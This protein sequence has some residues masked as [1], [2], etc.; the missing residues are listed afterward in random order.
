[1]PETDNSAPPLLDE[2]WLDQLRDTLEATNGLLICLDFDGTL[3]PIVDDPGEATIAPEN[4]PLLR[5]LAEDPDVTVVVVSGRSLS[6]LREHVGVDGIHYAGNHG[7]EWDDG[8]GRTVAPATQGT[9]EALREALGRIRS[10][11]ADIDGCT[12]EDKHLTATVHYRRVSDAQRPTVVEV[13]KRVVEPTDALRLRSGKEV[14]EIWPDVPGHKGRV[15]E[16]LRDRRPDT[17][18]LFIGDDVTDED[19]FR[20]VGEDGHGILVGDRSDTAASVRVPNPAGVTL[21]LTW[22]VQ[23]YVESPDGSLRY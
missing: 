11:L 7:L 5:R 1:M 2:V 16:R 8:S 4:E 23:M 19:G 10:L 3:A 17:V 9:R 21:F 20:A 6:D 12:I 14:L 18:P 22:L 13:T 15:V